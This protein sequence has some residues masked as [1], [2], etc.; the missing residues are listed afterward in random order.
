MTHGPIEFKYGNYEFKPAPVFNISTDGYKTSE[1]SGWGVNH[2]IVLDGDLLLTGCDTR[3]GVTGLFD[4]INT[5]RTSVSQDGYL[6][7]ATCTSGVDTE[8]IISGRPIV[9]SFSVENQGD[10]YTRRA[11]YSIEF[12]MPTLMMGTGQDTINP[13]GVDGDNTHPIAKIHPAFIESFSETWQSEFREKRTGS[14]FSGVYRD[15]T[16]EATGGPKSGSYSEG[17]LW[18]GSFSHTIDVKGR[19]TYTGIET[20]VSLDVKVGWRTAYDYATGYLNS[21]YREFTDE[22]ITEVCSSGLIGLPVT[23]PGAAV[24]LY[25]RFRNASINRVDNSVSVTETFNLQPDLEDGGINP[26]GAF[27]T[28][29]INLSTEGGITSVSVQGQIEGYSLIDYKAGSNYYGGS[30]LE[31]GLREEEGALK[32]AEK[33]FNNLVARKKF[34]QRAA[35]T[36]FKNEQL[37]QAGCSQPIRIFRNPKSTTYG[38]NP[39]QGVISYSFNYDNSPQGCITGECIISQN[40]TIDDQLEA[41]IFATQVILGRAQGPLLQDIGT[42]TAR[43]KTIS[44]EIVT[45]PPTSCSDLEEINKTNPSGIVGAFID[46]L[47]NDLT[48]NYNQIF[49]SSNSESWAF[50]Q[51][52]YTKNISFTYN[53]CSGV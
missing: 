37:I 4:R 40:I 11:K 43:V 9:N 49:T 51:G 25:N 31:N 38:V 2:K 36:A 26:G 35:A 20:P 10:N 21:K 5:L 17:F 12:A 19:T 33:Y 42:T 1:G 34:F 18:D 27:E 41:D 53:N 16:S 28:Y 46:V 44:V 52:R 8:P 45:V 6:L 47:H 13:S 48:S 15:P 29:D 39:L 7:V 22:S 23:N 3:Y 50:T 14:S 24:R 32:N 30:V